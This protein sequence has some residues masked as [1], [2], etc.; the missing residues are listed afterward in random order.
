MPVALSIETLLMGAKS[1]YP[2]FNLFAK[3]TSANR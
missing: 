1:G 2:A 3:G